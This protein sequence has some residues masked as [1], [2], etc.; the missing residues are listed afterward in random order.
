[1]SGG[2]GGQG[3]LGAGG[4]IAVGGGSITLALDLLQNNVAKGGQGGTGGDGAS[5]GGSFS[6]HSARVGFGGHAGGGGPG[7]KGGTGAE[8]S[9]AGGAGGS[10]GAGAS[11]G[12]GGNPGN[13]G[14]GGA[15]GNA[16]G[17]SIYV[18]GGALV[19]ASVTTVGNSV[20]AG[21]GGAAGS[22]GKP[23]GSGG[24]K[25][26]GG[27]GGAGGP[28]AAFAKGGG[29]APDGTDGDSGPA[30]K[31]GTNGA[32]A[33]AGS[34]GAS[35]VAS[36]PDNF[37]SGGT[38]TPQTL[39]VVITSPPPGSVAEGATFGVTAAVENSQHQVVTTFNGDITVV[40]SNPPAGASLNGPVTVRASGGVA[41]FSDLSINQAGS[42]YQLEATGG[43]TFSE[44][45]SLSVTSS[46]PPPPPT[47]PT[48]IGEMPLFSRKLNKHH[49]PV[50]KPI[51]TGFEIE[52]STAMNPASVG[53]AGNYQVDWISTKRAQ[54][55]PKHVL[56][57]VPIRAQ[58]NAAGDSVN[59]LLEGTQAFKD[60]GQ[61]TVVGAAP[62]G[63]SSALGVLLDGNNEGTS[64]DIG[65]F[66]ILPKA[67]GITRE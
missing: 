52:F 58:Y 28:G 15:G 38:I 33:A 21:D 44:P 59:L 46:L 45:A 31:Q 1:V 60:G 32:N 66:S 49:K 10:G 11:G 37:S 7:G 20:T 9:G 42:G 50:G 62:G 24:P 39:L 3:G 13:G 41:V 61:I 18:T 65:V 14:A 26:S 23:F 48:I 5:D 27:A 34:A 51:L 57:P 22:A 2:A 19:L 55:K 16:D 40:L 63:V 53:N 29:S 30:G 56:H 47:P 67:R 35:G 6:S 12:R 8:F 4:G 25:G 64:G 43:G 36:D 17:G 54:K